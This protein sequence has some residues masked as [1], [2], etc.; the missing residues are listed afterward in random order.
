MVT[1]REIRERFKSIVEKVDQQV[2]SGELKPIRVLPK[3]DPW[4]TRCG[5]QGRGARS[6]LRGGAEARID[7]RPPA[8]RDRRP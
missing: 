3:Q 2:A 5:A 7:A 6:D 4:R 1:P 8:A